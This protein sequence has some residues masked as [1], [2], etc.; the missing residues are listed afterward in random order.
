MRQPKAA[1]IRS[2]TRLALALTRNDDRQPALQQ[3]RG[4]LIERSTTRRD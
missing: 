4:E 3:I 1:M 2:T